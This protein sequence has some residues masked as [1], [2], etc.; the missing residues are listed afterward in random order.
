[1][2]TPIITTFFILSSV[3]E[4]SGSTVEGPRSIR[5]FSPDSL[6]SDDALRTYLEN[7]GPIAIEFFEHASFLTNP[8]L[9][10][11]APGSDGSTIA[12]QYITWNL[13]QN[14]LE[15]AFGDSWYQPFDF[16]IEGDAPTVTHALVQH[17]GNTLEQSVDYVVLGNS[18]NGSLT[19]P[20]TF[21][22]Y[23]IENG[24]D[25]YSSFD[26][27]TDLTGQIALMLRYEPLDQEGVSLWSG[28]RFGPKSA[29]RDKMQ[30]VVDRGAAGVIL[31]NPP[32]CRDGRR[33][34]ETMRSNR[35]GSTNIPVVQFS[36]AAASDLLG[37]LKK[38]EDFQSSAD[39]GSVTTVPLDADLTLETA[40]ETTGMRAQNV[41]G[42]LQG[43]GELAKEWV[44]IG[45]H[46]DH[47]GFGYTGTSSRGELHVGA[48]DN[49]SG[50][51]A[52]LVL[53]GQLAEAYANNDDTSLRSVLFLLFDA[54]E[55]G[56]YGSDAFVD[57]PIMDLADIN[58]MINMDM[59]GRLRNNNLSISGTGTATE[60]EELVPKLV[61]NTSMTASL[62]TGGTGPSD[63]TNFYIN[64]I[65]VLF[66]FTGLSDEYHTPQDRLHTLNPAGAAKVIAL[67]RTFADILVDEPKVHFTTN[68]KTKSNR[69]TTM[70]SPVRLGV[71]PSYTEQL[72]TGILLTGVSEGTCAE[73]AGLQ[74]DDVLLAWDE[75]ELTGGRKL[76]ELLKESAPGD[77]VTFT[78]RRD[79]ENIFVEVTLKAP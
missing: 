22:G 23:A 78:V 43:R 3:A 56:L 65:P 36:H 57:D 21:V 38:L 19:A 64:D 10:G 70:S 31:V 1:M 51:A 20:V 74:A 27:D 17:N 14:G 12:G 75:I 62:T 30:A 46:Y 25:D 50:T 58:V 2:F 53:A 42:I 76:M 77:V 18:G 69:A 4:P 40:V 9:A 47:L 41:G 79:D 29:I 59:V 26:D 48:D 34:L 52:V 7:A 13:E 8:W 71:H 32:N 55:A 54:E 49:A 15:P 72:E 67:V 33:G 6:A 37:G 28:R 16:D 68:T 60:F 63:H 11:R 35:F 66:F 39:T 5:S 44:V 24:N 73:E 45:G 61:E